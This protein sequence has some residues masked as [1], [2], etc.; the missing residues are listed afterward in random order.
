MSAPPPAQNSFPML[1]ISTEP[2]P[3]GEKRDEKLG[4]PPRC[5]KKPEIPVPTAQ[6]ALTHA[7][8][9][10]TPSS[11]FEG[12]ASGSNPRFSWVE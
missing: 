6:W 9:L 2:Q 12:E 10:F 11:L 5:A 8:H 7:C 4:K 3:Y 1:A